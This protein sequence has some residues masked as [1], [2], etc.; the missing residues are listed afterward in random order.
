MTSGT[1]MDIDPNAGE[2]RLQIV[3]SMLACAV[4]ALAAAC[5]EPP[6]APAQGGPGL[7][8]RIEADGKPGNPAPATIRFILT[9][10]GRDSLYVLDWY[11]P[12]EGMQGNL[13]DVTRDGKE[14]SYRGMMVKRG[15]PGRE[16]YHPLQPGQSLEA[17]VSL[18]DG[19]EVSSP[20]LYTVTFD[21]RGRGD[22]T[23][24]AGTLPRPRGDHQGPR[25]RSNSVAF[26]VRP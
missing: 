3:K 5:A 10:R 26:T 11:T 13:F 12:L 23:A 14:V 6:A 21:W 1:R 8:V 18:A 16:S 25:L 17:R 7:E 19:Y 20:G 4:V 22:V 24:D 15:D 2:G 9:N